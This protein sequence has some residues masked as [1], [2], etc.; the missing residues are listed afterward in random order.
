MGDRSTIGGAVAS[1]TTGDT[2]AL[3]WKD[4]G[5]S[6]THAKITSVT[7]S[8]IS[9]GA[10]TTIT[11]TGS[12][13]EDVNDGTFDMKV[14]GIGGTQLLECKGD[15]SA[16]KT[17]NLPLGTGSITFD[18]VK[19]PLKAGPQPINVDLKLSSTLPAS[20]AKTKTTVTAA[21]KSGDKLFCLEVDLAKELLHIV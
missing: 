18:G 11:G 6:S 3:T 10:L 4:C 21:S 16:S 14:V 8:T 12:L 9:L 2:L 19:F 17:C 1:G 15:A 20:L 13:D 7:P 5:D